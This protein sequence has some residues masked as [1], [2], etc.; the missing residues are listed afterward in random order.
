MAR[1]KM[2]Y[3]VKPWLVI[4]GL[5]GLTAVFVYG[6]ITPGLSALSI[7]ASYLAALGALSGVIRGLFLGKPYLEVQFLQLIPSANYY[8]IFFE[9]ANVGR[10]NV[11][12][13]D[14]SYQIVDSHGNV[15]DD[16][17]ERTTAW[18]DLPKGTKKDLQF[19]FKPLLS[20]RYTFY[21]LPVDCIPEE[22][23]V[24]FLAP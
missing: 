3:L 8:T 7:F 17:S 6:V 19:Q 22:F 12:E 2:L 16:S 14:C 15:V 24:R 9:I 21:W 1:G 10:V 5:L 20:G 18:G 13:G 4:V 23:K 11:V